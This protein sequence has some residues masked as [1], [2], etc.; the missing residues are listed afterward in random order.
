VED[1]TAVRKATRRPD[2]ALT[3]LAATSA[4]AIRTEALHFLTGGPNEFWDLTDLVR[5]VVARS[6]VR[7]GQVTIGTPHTTTTLVVNE[8]ETGFLNDFRKV[9]TAMVPEDAY[10]EHDDHSVRTENVQEDEFI[11]GH[12]HCRQLLTGQPSVTL[13]VVEGEVLLGQWQKVMFVELDQ[14]RERRAF[15]HAQGV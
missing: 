1:R 7:H 8:A 5:E 9:I 14:A 10:Y 11:N 2:G 4:P 15:F 12:A 13:P 3:V 6:G